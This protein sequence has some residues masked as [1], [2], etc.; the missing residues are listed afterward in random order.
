MPKYRD[1]LIQ[2]LTIFE[3]E[4]EVISLDN[5]ISIHDK[6]YY[7]NDEPEI[8]DADYD[9]LRRRLEGLVQRFPALQQLSP[10]LTRVGATP[11]P[12][13]SKVTHREPML[14]LANAFDDT[15]VSDFLLRVTKFLSLDITRDI[16]IVSEPKIDG[17][18]ASLRYEKGSFVVGATRGDG[19]VG[20]DITD[21][22]RTINDIP[23][24]LMGDFPDTLEIRGETVSYTHLTLP[25]KA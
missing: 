24:A 25:T 13:F 16:E 7:Q 22:L 17:V 6:M 18:S 21:N 20:E 12:A 2:N 1:K 11:S 9:R 15:D 10:R 23:L 19:T 8:D 4:E 14:S 3:A 5:E